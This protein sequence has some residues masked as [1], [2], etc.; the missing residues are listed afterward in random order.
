MRSGRLGSA[1]SHAD[2]RRGASTGGA[3]VL[4]CAIGV[5][6]VYAN[7]RGANE[8]GKEVGA[9]AI[10]ELASETEEYEAHIVEHVG[11]NDV[12][13]DVRTC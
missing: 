1:A 3:G 11:G 10:D 6:E 12:S 7:E 2:S 13:N 8:C 5:G 9:R 4:V